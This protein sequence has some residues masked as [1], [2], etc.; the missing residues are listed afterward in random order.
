MLNNLLQSQ[1]DATK[2]N[3]NKP[4]DLYG[5]NVWM[6]HVMG[7]ER[8]TKLAQILKQSPLQLESHVFE[9]FNSNEGMI[10]ILLL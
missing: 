7:E 2:F 8:R 10:I 5:M 6:I 4:K 1:A 3:P 9:F